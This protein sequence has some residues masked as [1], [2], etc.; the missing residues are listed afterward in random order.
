MAL[1]PYENILVDE[2]AIA[3]NV[4]IV[5]SDSRSKIFLARRTL[6][7]RYEFNMSCRVIPSK[8]FAANAYL[9]S[10]RA[11]ATLTELSL[12]FYGETTVASK[13]V[14]AAAATG[15]RAATLSN[16]TGIQA[17]MFFQFSGHP[18]LYCVTSIAGSAINFEP[19]LVRPLTV[20]QTVKFTDLTISCRLNGTMPAI[21][22][23]GN[24]RPVSFNL[25]FVE[26]L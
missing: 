22:S 4:S 1:F 7:Q 11:G 18:K 21:S 23:L 8:F 26:A 6:G 17:G 12:P 19:N 25:G 20:G 3:S 10:L 24:R 9:T 5:T 2:L 13:T 15:L 16:I 14:S